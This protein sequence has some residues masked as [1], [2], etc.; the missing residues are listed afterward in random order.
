M[1]LQDYRL[2]N[3]F[4]VNSRELQLQNCWIKEDSV[5]VSNVFRLG[6]RFRGVQNLRIQ[7]WSP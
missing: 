3:W 1:E 6:R 5:A 2:T 4:N 7:L